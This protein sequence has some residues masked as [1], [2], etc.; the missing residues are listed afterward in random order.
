MK[1]YQSNLIN[2][3][4]ENNKEKIEKNEIN[5]I[6]DENIEI[7]IPKENNIEKEIINKVKKKKRYFGIDLIRVLSC[8]L[9]IL[10]HSG[11]LYYI[12]EEGGLIKS[13]NN[14]WPGFFNSLSRVCVPLFVIISGYLLL[15]IKTDYKTF[16]KKRVTRIITPFFS[17]CIFY[18]IYHFIKGEFDWKQLLLHIP[19]IFLN[20]GTNLGHLWYI[21]MNLGLYLFMPIIS[22]WIE[23]AEKVH[24]YYYFIIWI[25]SSTTGYIKIFYG[26][27]WGEAF[28]NKTTTVS[29]FIGDFGYAVFGAF[30]KIHL[31]NKK[32]Y[33][34][35]IILYIIGSGVTML[36]YFY[37]RDEAKTTFDIEVTWQFDS[38]NVL[39]ASCGLFLLLRKVDCKNKIIN[40]IFNDIALKSFG[41]YLIHMFFIYLFTYV[42]DARNQFP[43]WC[44]FALA[45]ITFITSYIIIKILSY[46]PYSQY[47]IG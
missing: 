10:F 19:Q 47:I 29:G 18:D 16:F 20:Y 35:G 12:D 38:V 34:L 6:N 32:Y 25:I 15:P 8:F 44:I 37:K 39:I 23:K 4:E 22:P 2:L 41:M 33:F 3:K 21:Y 24:F 11:C 27:V 45:G 17:F 26:E 46:I 36:G 1:D 13:E 14:I 31:K 30:C 40:K 7:N 43:A 9:V 5:S 42:L 28:W